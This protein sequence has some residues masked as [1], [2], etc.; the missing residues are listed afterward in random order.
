MTTNYLIQRASVAQEA[1]DR[2]E[3]EGGR[4]DQ[5]EYELLG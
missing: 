5:L 4:I 3:N 2:W 1:L